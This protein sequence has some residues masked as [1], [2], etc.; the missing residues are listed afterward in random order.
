MNALNS[1]GF[2]ADIFLPPSFCLN[3][4]VSCCFDHDM[5][6][7]RLL[8]VCCFLTQITTAAPISVVVWDEQQPAQKTAYPNFLG[9]EI[10]SYPQTVPNLSAKSVSLADPEQRLSNE[11]LEACHV[12]IWWGHEWQRIPTS[13]GLTRFASAQTLASACLLGL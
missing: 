5:K 3:R 10:A 7:L 1:W 2:A 8:V 4:S 9:N 11:N 6:A 13:P 12:L